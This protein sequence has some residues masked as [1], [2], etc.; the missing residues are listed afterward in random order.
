MRKSLR[1][2]AAL[3]IANIISLFA[4]S[5]TTTISGNVKNSVTGDVVSAAS[6]TVKGS[7][8]GTFTDDRG[9]FTLTTT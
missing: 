9:N 7:G 4:F 3:L 2:L 8:A 5:Q 6:I 1:C